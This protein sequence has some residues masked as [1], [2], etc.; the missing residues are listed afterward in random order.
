MKT[1]KVSEL[2]DIALCYVICLLEMPNLKWGETVSIHHA[3]RQIVVPELP[4]FDCYSPFLS[5]K[6]FGPII[7]REQ[8]QLQTSQGEW[9][10]STP[11]AVEIGGSRKY[12]FSAGPSPL[13]A[14]MRCYVAS[15]FGD[16]IEIPEELLPC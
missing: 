5:W 7:E 4:E 12:C 13:I 2:P 15:K 11:R 16:T 10:A 9:V 3:S 1:V 8:L 6:M 14:A